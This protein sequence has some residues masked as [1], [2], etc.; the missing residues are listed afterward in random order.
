MRIAGVDEVGR[1]PLAGPVVAAAVVFKQGYQNSEIKDSK[2]LSPKKREELIEVIKRDALEWAIVSVGPR[3]IEALN[4]REASRLANNFPFAEVAGRS[5]LS[6]LGIEFAHGAGAPAGA[7][8]L[9]CDE[10]HPSLPL[11]DFREDARFETS[12]VVG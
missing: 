6:R 2:Q 4:I 11:V 8:D 7:V 5:D 10:V 1:G 9:T 12:H 3:R